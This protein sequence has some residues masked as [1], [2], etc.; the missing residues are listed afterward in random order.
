MLFNSYA[1]QQFLRNQFG[2]LPERVWWDTDLR[3]DLHLTDGEIRAVLTYLTRETGTAFPIDTVEH[4]TNVFDL[5]VYAFLRSTENDPEAY[6]NSQPH[7]L[8][9]LSPDK[10][11]PF[12]IALLQ[13][14]LN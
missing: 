14:N 3:Q 11:R 13:L 2:I 9:Y 6:F 8:S 7:P 4:L 10:F 5:M 12:G 1:L